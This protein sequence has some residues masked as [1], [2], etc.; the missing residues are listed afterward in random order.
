MSDKTKSKS[1]QCEECGTTESPK[2]CSLKKSVEEIGNEI[3][4]TRREEKESQ[5]EEEVEFIYENEEDAIIR[6][7]I[8]AIVREKVINEELESTNEGDL[9]VNTEKE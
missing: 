1:K 8:D 7:K 3:E 9:D 6:D 2:F 4:T 5:V